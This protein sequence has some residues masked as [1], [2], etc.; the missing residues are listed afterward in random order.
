MIYRVLPDSI[1]QKFVNNINIQHLGGNS[2]PA[3]VYMLLDDTDPIPSK[4][5]NN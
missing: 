5:I 3:S 1:L 2:I 4:Q